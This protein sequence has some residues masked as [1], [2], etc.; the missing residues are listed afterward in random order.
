M[1]SNPI[2]PELVFFSMV[3][4]VRYPLP[5]FLNSSAF[6]GSRLNGWSRAASFY[7]KSIRRN[8]LLFDGP[9]AVFLLR[10]AAMFLGR[11]GRRA[12]HV[13]FVGDAFPFPLPSRCS[14]LFP[15][16]PGSLSN[17]RTVGLLPRRFGPPS[18][19]CL[20]DCQISSLHA[21]YEAYRLNIP[22]IGLVEGDSDP[23][24]FVYPV[25]LNGFARLARQ[26]VTSYL[27][28]CLRRSSLE[29]FSPRRRLSF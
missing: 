28:R 2:L 23:S 3:S 14:L 21:A 7:F 8:F 13:L 26:S 12:P 5:L 19:L 20:L 24:W 6:Y 27:L 11:L 25:P 9:K 15:Y 10:R 18:L 4:P 29:A 1:G 16:K 17:Y 22:S